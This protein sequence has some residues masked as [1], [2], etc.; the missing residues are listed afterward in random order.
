MKCPRIA[1]RIL[2]VFFVVFSVGIINAQYAEAAPPTDG[3]IV[4]VCIGW[5]TPHVEIRWSANPPPGSLPPNSNSVLRDVNATGN[6]WFFGGGTPGVY[7]TRINGSVAAPYGTG[8]Y[9]NP[10]YTVYDLRDDSVV[11]NA[12]YTY[13]TKYRPETS[14]GNVY[15]VI[16]NQTNCGAGPSPTPWL[17]PTPTPLPL[18]LS[19]NFQTA[20]PNVTTVLS[21]TGG[22]GSY[23]WT[24]PTGIISGTGSVVSVLYTN[25]LV[26]PAYKTVTVQSGAQTAMATVQVDGVETLRDDIL[27][28]GTGPRFVLIN[29]DAPVASSSDVM[30]I[31]G[32]GF[33]NEATVSM[34]MKLGNSLAS[35]S[36]AIEQPFQKYLPWNLCT[37]LALCGD[38]MYSV[39]A[40]YRTPVGV[41][42]PVV[43]DNIVYLSDVQRST[44]AVAINNDALSTTERQVTLVLTNGLKGIPADEV[45]MQIANA[46]ELVGTAM[47]QLYSPTLAGWDLCA[48]LGS[49]CTNGAKIVYAKY[50]AGNTCTVVVLDN[51]LLESPWP[52]WGIVINDNAASTTTAAVQLR[53]NPWFNKP[54]T[55]VFFSNLADFSVLSSS[56]F[57]EL[58]PWDLCAGL[59]SCPLT[60]RTV[61]VRYVNYDK[62]TLW[63][64]IQSP[65]Y[66]DDIVLG[67]VACSPRPACLDATPACKPP[68]PQG[69]WCQ[70]PSPTPTPKPTPTCKPR[71]A[72]LDLPRFACKPPEPQ[73]GW[74]PVASPTPTPSGSVT[75]TPS[76]RVSPSVTPSIG[77]PF[78]SPPPSVFIQTLSGASDVIEPISI[79][80]AVAVGASAVVAL[81]PILGSSGAG[82]FLWQGLMG[83]L[84]LL[85]KRKKVWGTVYDSNTK[86]PIPFAKVQLMDRNKRVL[87]THIAD[88]DG[89]YGFLTT[90]ESLLA[91]NVQI[92]ILPSA[93]DYLFPAHT[94]ASVD[95]L[96]Y[97]NLYYGD[98]ITVND[99]T[100]INFDIP[101]DPVRPSAAPLV[102]KSPSIVL[103]ASVAAIADAGFW[104]G[105]I[106]IPLNAIIAP[107]PF[108]LGVLFLFLG[109][110]SLRIWGISEHPFGT[111]TDSAT[112]R[113]MP[114]ALIT[115]NDLSGKHVGF[116]V[117]DERGRYF[118]VA[119]KGTY[120][121]TIFTPATIVP[122]RQSKQII[123]ARKGWI[124]REIKI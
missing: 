71:P 87:E 85:P 81:M 22:D 25:G 9:P 104:L 86:R 69:G 2:L 92:S 8:G 63:P 54:G 109:T 120:E 6:Q 124:T 112:G 16:I 31:L 72:C 100:L 99:K 11:A 40:I 76:G 65:D 80:S 13:K 114:F 24:A 61:Y 84:G 46:K 38:G 28:T 78:G 45:T 27:L 23:V 50:C 18:S 107:S 90:P 41:S 5:P 70:A 66:Q 116:T 10:N 52:D 106:M 123:E 64:G 32:H 34:T 119:D 68:E 15:S 7:A 4:G 56:A 43:L 60:N 108:T 33:A 35:A 59:A 89:R 115:L 51:I 77:P 73:E 42:S 36:A 3:Q 26:T 20:P 91:Q 102:V 19:P 48:G 62:S 75:P 93:R 67:A 53:L 14:S 96:V 39:Y 98:L 17:T 113:P 47:P 110:A 74:C 122:I 58:V 111:I 49:T 118:L 105:L 44:P 82:A 21:A 55:E 37:G 95:T 83:M 88:K 1:W 97:N 30:L 94:A 121:M 57:K 12:T 103:G 29:N 117:S 101:M 79:A